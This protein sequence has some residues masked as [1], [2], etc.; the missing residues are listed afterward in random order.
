MNNI[1]LV[2][3]PGCGKSTVGVV[4]AKTL[5][6]DFIDTDLIICKKEKSKLQKII[7]KKGI[8]YFSSVECTVGKELD[9]SDTVVATGGSMVL[10]EEAMEHLKSIGKV[11][12]ID[13]SFEELEHRITNIK[14][15]GITF[16]EGETLRD[17]YDFRRPYYE[18]YADCTVK[19]TEGTIENTV[20]K[21][22]KLLSE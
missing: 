9:L 21:L 22:V 20:E 17:I 14:T 1:I 2:G 6:L 13:V 10:Y 8:D 18:K 5:G 4:L 15:R 7:E 11:V 12:F 19:I 16:K 3:M